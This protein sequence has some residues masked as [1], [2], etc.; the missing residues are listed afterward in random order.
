MVA[1][2]TRED[3][4]LGVVTPGRVLQRKKKSMP[5]SKLGVPIDSMHTCSLL[6]RGTKDM[7]RRLRNNRLS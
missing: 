5:L 7:K 4:V 1:S 3:S 6:V 2:A